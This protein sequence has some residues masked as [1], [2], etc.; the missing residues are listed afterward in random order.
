MKYKVTRRF[1][2]MNVEKWFHPGD[3]ISE[4]D[5]A[6]QYLRDIPEL[7]EPVVEVEEEVVKKEARSD[8]KG[9][10]HD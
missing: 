2:L 4:T 5:E 7:I 9:K 6:F 8:K 10:K 1:Y 3:I